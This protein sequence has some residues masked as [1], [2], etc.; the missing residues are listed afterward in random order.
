MY[1]ILLLLFIITIIILY[2]SC[3][4]NINRD[5]FDNLQYCNYPK[6]RLLVKDCELMEGTCDQWYQDKNGSLNVCEKNVDNISIPLLKAFPTCKAKMSECNPYEI[7]IPCAAD[8]S[9][10]NKSSPACCG[11]IGNVVPPRICPSN[12]PICTGF[13]QGITMGQCIVN[14]NGEQFEKNL[15]PEE[16][17][18]N[19]IISETNNTH[20]ALQ[21]HTESED[22]LSNRKTSESVPSEEIHHESVP[23]EE[24]PHE[25]IE[26]FYIMTETNNNSKP[27]ISESCCPILG[28]D[29][30]NILLKKYN[31]VQPFRLNEYQPDKINRKDS[32]ESG[33]CGCNRNI[34]WSSNPSNTKSE[35]TEIQRKF[36]DL[37]SKK[38]INKPRNDNVISKP[39]DTSFI[40]CL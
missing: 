2:N 31:N 36:N 39:Y 40:S 9:N 34:D 3:T 32:T 33:S 15:S 4:Y 13:K 37:N 21:E 17:T 5:G 35:Y 22:L 14:I 1:Y 29:I 20:F 11:Q 28:I 10:N 30:E 6:E 18:S 23:S 7:P 27:P 26:K 25:S 16:I 8:Y 24:I 19:H 12:K 38:N